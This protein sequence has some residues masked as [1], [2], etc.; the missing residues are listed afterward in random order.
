MRLIDCLIDYLY[1]EDK[2]DDKKMH[3][4]RGT[5][6]LYTKEILDE[7]RTTRKMHRNGCWESGEG[8]VSGWNRCDQGRQILE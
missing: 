4:K 3:E 7:T 2:A 8:L 6:K 5:I 1:E